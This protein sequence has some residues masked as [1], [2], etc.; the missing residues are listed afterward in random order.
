MRV[1]QFRHIR[2]D[3]QCSGAPIGIFSVRRGLLVAVAAALALLLA[4]ASSGRTSHTAPGQVELVALLDGKPLAERPHARAEIEREQAEVVRRIREAV[5]TAR[6]RWRYQL[7]LNGLA[8]IAPADSPVSSAESAGDEAII[9]PS[10]T[11]S[12]RLASR[13]VRC[14]CA[15]DAGLSAG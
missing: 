8:V 15:S 10:K 5:P 12:G 9:Q 4:G 1:Y 14:A 11:G 3:G 6:V 2:A 13:I 7:V